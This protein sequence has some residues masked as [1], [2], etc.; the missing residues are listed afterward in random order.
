MTTSPRF[1]NPT[2]L[3]AALIVLCAV[4]PC[5]AITLTLDDALA[6]AR[7][8]SPRVQTAEQQIR[9]AHGDLT[10]ART[11]PNP[12]LAGSTGNFAL[13]HTNPHG[14]DASDTVVGQVGISEEIILPGK[15]RAQ[16]EAAESGVAQ[17]EAERSDTLRDV[18]TSV[19]Q[20]F[21]TAQI[22]TEAVRVARENLAR[23]RDTVR[24]NAQRATAG[25][26]APAEADRIAL[27]EAGFEKLVAD[28]EGDRRTALATLAE[29]LGLEPGEV[30]TRG[31]IALPSLSTNVDALTTQ[32]LEQRADLRASE[33]AADA[34]DANLRLAHANAIPNPTVGVQYTHSEFQVSG[35]LAD[36]MGV[37]LSLP[38]P[39]LDRNQGGIERS[40]AEAQ[41]AHSAVDTLKRTIPREI[42]TAAAAYT[43]ARDRVQHFERDYL[44]Q[45]GR[46]RA[47]AEASYRE[48]AISLLELLEAERAAR[49][50]QRDYLDALRDG[51]VAAAA[52]QHAAGVEED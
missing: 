20:Q 2:R 18:A 6:L 49:Q 39:I 34:A 52:L 10:T 51:H 14:L 9:A 42:A 31:P 16:R 38:L 27:E 32:A 5:G 41:M 43:A 48:G 19:R 25:A 36:S 7:Q 35:D 12:V 4:A 11:Y 40:A 26:I 3:S 1:S 17:A 30:E 22:A 50:T 33:H 24:V 23:Y 44:Q 21:A 29:L 46:A 15:R 8:H 28:A 45:A 13:G 37:S 47:A